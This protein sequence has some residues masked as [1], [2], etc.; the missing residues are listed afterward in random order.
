MDLERDVI[1]RNDF[2]VARRGYD[3]D[4]VDRFLI[5]VQR[6]FRESRPMSVDEVRKVVFHT[7]RGGYSEAQ[8][9]LLLDAVIDVMLAVR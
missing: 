5:R 6:Y 9:D 4:E 3:P 1:E 8:V 2:P 7:R